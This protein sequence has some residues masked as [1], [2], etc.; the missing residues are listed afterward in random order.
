MNSYLFEDIRMFIA[1]LSIKA[2]IWQQ[3]KGPTKGE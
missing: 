3:P 2:K 1:A